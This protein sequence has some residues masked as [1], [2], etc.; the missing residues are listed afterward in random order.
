MAIQ[1]TPVLIPYLIS[2][3]VT[4]GLAIYGFRQYREGTGDSDT[5]LAFVGIM[6]SASIW[7]AAR[8]LQF[9]FVSETI[10]EFFLGTLYI[11]YGGVTMSALFFGLAFSGRKE[12][13]QR[14]Y[15][16]ALLVIPAIAV[17][18]ALTNPIHELFWTAAGDELYVSIDQIGGDT[19][20]WGD[21]EAFDRSFQPL[22]Y[23]YLAYT[24]GFVLVGLGLLARTALGSAEV[25]WRQGVSI[26]AGSVIALLTGILF[27]ASSQPL[28]PDFIDLSPMGFAIMGLLFGYA[29]FRQQLL[30]VLPVARDTV[31]EGMRDGY[32]VL[33]TEDRLLDMN[34]AAS[35]LFRVEQDE[36]VG[37]PVAEGIPQLTEPVEEHEYGTPSE[38]EIEIQGGGGRVLSVNVSALYEDG[39]LVGRLL[40]L[41]DVTDQ[42]RVQRRYQALIENSTDLILVVDRD[43][44]ITYASPSVE[45][46]AGFEPEAITGQNVLDALHEEDRERIDEAFAELL[47]RP[48]D[49][50]REEFRTF[51]AEGNII[52]MEASARNL[53]SNP[54]VNGLVVNAREV[55]ERKRRERELREAN[56][57]LEEFAS[58]VSH[59]LRSPLTV[60]RGHLDMAKATGDEEHFEQIGSSLDRIDNI[61]EDVLALTRGGDTVDEMLAV[62]LEQASREAWEH[63]ETEGAELV[64]DDSVSIEADPSRLLQLLENLFRNAIEHGAPGEGPEVELGEGDPETFIIRVGYDGRLYVEDSGAGIP[65]ENREEILETGYSTSREGTGLGLSIVKKI[66]DAH[67]WEV[68]I[69]EGIEGGARFE[70][71]GVQTASTE[72]EDRQEA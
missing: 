64:V 53:L 31:I 30:D 29:V 67:Y 25:Y 27:A 43:R 23:A 45:R 46:I 37:E 18:V 38:T 5:A 28:V 10:S 55:T 17:L 52:H 15:V 16:G 60:A 1:F 69:T 62:E 7:S 66:A 34:T 70:F 6:F 41:Q 59:D 63:V 9:L 42:Q 24:V 44:E 33:D 57:Q 8:F 39:R 19:G 35:D 72:S 49:E 65:E 71:E 3:V 47:N 50:F 56:E 40:L 20:L 68:N 61:I 22:F 58:I 12:W 11:G 36:V 4:L 51:D 26:L 2:L 13:L 14:R 54:Y 48:D 32:V 21:I